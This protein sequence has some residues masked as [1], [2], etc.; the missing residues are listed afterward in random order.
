MIELVGKAQAELHALVSAHRNGNGPVQ[1]TVR[2][3]EKVRVEKLPCLIPTG[4]FQRCEVEFE[5]GHLDALI[6]GCCMD[7][8]LVER[9]TVPSWSHSDLQD[10]LR[11]GVVRGGYSG[12]RPAGSEQQNEGERKAGQKGVMHAHAV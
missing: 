12:V 2:H 1:W 7:R 3:V 11:S 10:L 6:T 9:S 4:E 5:L 8:G